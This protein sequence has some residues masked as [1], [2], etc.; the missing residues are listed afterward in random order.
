MF[1][2]D[3]HKMIRAENVSVFGIGQASR[4]SD[5]RSGYRPEDFMLGV[6]SVICFGIPIPQG[7]YS[8]TKYN[9]EA[10]WRS[11][12]LLYRRLDTLSLRIST[13]L[14]ENGAR[15]IPIYGC[16]PLGV[17]EKGTVVGILNQLRMAEITGIGVIGKNGLLIHSQYGSRLMLGG[18]ITTAPLPVMRHPDGEEP[19]C[20]SD[21]Q[22]CSDACPVNAILPERKQ[23]N[24]M[25]CLSYTARTPAMSRLKF[26]F[27]RTR[28]KKE[29][30]R[31]MSITSFDEHTFH[32][33]SNCVSLCPYGD[34]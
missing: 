23:V 13:L 11:Q 10:T 26:L 5:E 31:Y 12:N 20:P 29:A 33:C 25:R 28:N 1:T 14:E 30:A 4:M 16:M 17:S 8:A 2:E 6:Q 3:L 27:L 7:V 18:L 34:K 21:C 24:I 19:G 9:L 22:I 15:A 32:A